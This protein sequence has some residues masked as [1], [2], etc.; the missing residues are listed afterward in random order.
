MH[1]NL[2]NFRIVDLRQIFETLFPNKVTFSSVVMKFSLSVSTLLLLSAATAF[3]TPQ[4]GLL[5]SI[6]QSIGFQISSELSF[7]LSAL[8]VSVQTNG[9][10]HGSSWSW[11]SLTFPKVPL[12]GTRH[13]HNLNWPTN[14]NEASDHLAGFGSATRLTTNGTD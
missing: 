10:S 14:V 11:H 9:T 7:I 12:S 4:S 3:P 5:S 6:I 8:G 2:F 1:K 13:S